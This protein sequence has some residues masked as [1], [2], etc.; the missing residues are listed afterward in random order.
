MHKDRHMYQW[1]R[2]E[3]PEIKPHIHNQSICD[4]EAKNTQWGKDSLLNK[5]GWGKCAVICKRMKLDY[6]ITTY[7][8]SKPKWIETKFKAWNHK[9]PRGE[10]KRKLLD[11]G[12]GSDFFKSDIKSNKSKNKQ[13]GPHQTKKLLYSKRKH[14]Q[15][16]Q[17]ALL[18]GGV[19][20]II[21]LQIPGICKSY[22]WQGV[23][24]QNIK[25][26]HTNQ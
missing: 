26:T 10:Q 6:C 12:L 23:D 17:A 2:L 24:N 3:S 7:I 16:K 15:K 14:Q 8:K 25:R 11:I 18:N 20:Q 1:N 13:V 4:K 19:L 9:T 21:I 22:V 5:W